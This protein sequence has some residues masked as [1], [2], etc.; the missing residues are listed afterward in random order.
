MRIFISSSSSSPSPFPASRFSLR[1]L[2]GFTLIEIIVVIAILAALVAIAAPYIYGNLKAA[3]VTACRS[4]LEQIY[5]LGNR[6]SQDMGHKNLLPTSG[7]DDDEDTP[8]IDENEGWWYAVAAEMDTTVLPQK[9]GAPMKISSIFHCKGDTRGKVTDDMM[10]ANIKNVSYVSWTDGSEDRKNPNSCIRTSAKQ[11][12]DTLPWL[13]DGVPVKGQSVTDLASFK[14]MVMP[15]LQ[16]HQNTLVVLY[17][18]GITKAIEADEEPKASV[19][20]KRIAPTLA[21]S[22]GK[23]KGAVAEEEDDSPVSPSSDD[24]ADSSDDSSDDSPADD[25]ADDEEE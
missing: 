22:K 6:Y 4:N 5:Q 18:S 20:F 14:K 10:V 9:K 15:A 17:A 1:R 24:G 21:S 8:F 16:R 23:K 19:L 7:M 3:D 25:S 13:S 12:L 11:N 2:L